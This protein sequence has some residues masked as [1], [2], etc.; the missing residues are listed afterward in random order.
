MGPISVE[1]CVIYLGA[2][3]LEK[4]VTSMAVTRP[5]ATAAWEPRTIGGAGLSAQALAR[6]TRECLL[7]RR[8]DTAHVL[9]IRPSS[10][11]NVPLSVVLGANL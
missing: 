2:R 6:L 11:A 5:F 3:V 7:K 8:A 10:L 1:P 9:V 4:Q